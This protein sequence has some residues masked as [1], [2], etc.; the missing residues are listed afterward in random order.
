[1]FS[2]TQLSKYLIF[3]HFLFL[4]NVRF[5]S[6]SLSDMTVQ[7]ISLGSLLL[8]GQNKLFKLKHH[9]CLCKNVENQCLKINNDIN[10]CAVFQIM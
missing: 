4:E 8:V 2:V 1:M 3:A 5:C 7:L 9:L 10:C 6:F